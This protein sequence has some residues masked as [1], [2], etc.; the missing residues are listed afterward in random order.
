[1][2]LSRSFR[3]PGRRLDRTSSDTGIKAAMKDHKRRGVLVSTSSTR[4][5]RWRVR[6]MLTERGLSRTL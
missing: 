3:S 2:G 5:K 4:Y 1:M 6:Q